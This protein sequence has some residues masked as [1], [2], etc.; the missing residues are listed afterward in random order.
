MPLARLSWEALPAS[1]ACASDGC[2]QNT[3]SVQQNPRQ[4]DQR[5]IH[6]VHGGCD[7]SRQDGDEGWLS[8]CQQPPDQRM[9]D[10]IMSGRNGFEIIEEMKRKG[11]LSY[12]LV[13][14]CI[15]ALVNVF[16]DE[17]VEER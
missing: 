1:M 5:H 10:V 6:W 12:T 11:G 4:H 9:L 15:K 14:A 2:A 7:G 16:R 17:V 8:L 3:E 13:S